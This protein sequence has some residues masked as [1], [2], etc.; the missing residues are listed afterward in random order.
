MTYDARVRVTTARRGT[1]WRA[2]RS[3]GIALDV[4]SARTRIW[5]RGGPGAHTVLDVPTVSFGPAGDTGVLR[6]VARGAVVDPEGAA[7]LLTRLL[8]PRVPRYARPVIVCA[9]P[10]PGGPEHRAA[11]AAALAGLRPRTVLAIDAVRALALAAGADLSRPLLVV[12]L[13]AQLTEVALLHDGVVTA[14]RRIERGTADLGTADLGTADLGAGDDGGLT[15]GRLAA[16]VGEAVADLLRDEPGHRAAEALGR[17]P[18]LG[19][20]G[21]LRAELVYRLARQLDTSV[22]PVPRPHTA[23]VRG[24]GEALLSARRHPA[25]A[26]PVTPVHPT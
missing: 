2:L 20:G 17:G 13:G 25:L 7:R 9:T 8:A 12:D 15:A 5:T 3:P 6:P 1:A 18:L 16:R 14:A 21:A 26:A 24:A 22:H 19:G 11:L 4:G 23:A 10:V